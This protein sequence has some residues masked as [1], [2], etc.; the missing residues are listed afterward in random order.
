M[1]CRGG[2]Q[3]IYDR[4]WSSSASCSRR[5]SPPSIRDLL[6]DRQNSLG[7]PQCEFVFQPR[8]QGCPPPAVSKHGNSFAYLPEREHAYVQKRLVCALDPINHARIRARPHKLGDE[9][10]VE[11]KSTQSSMSLPVSLSRVKSRFKPR[12]GDCWKNSTKLCGCRARWT[13]SSN[14]SERRTTTCSLPDLV[15]YCG[16]SARARRKSSLNFAFASCNCHAC[17]FVFCILV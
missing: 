7:E 15:T 8:F 11:Q 1:Q 6:T 10:G 17:L 9:I 12:K 4:Q 14:C 13:I 3:T 16:P 5:D 2:K